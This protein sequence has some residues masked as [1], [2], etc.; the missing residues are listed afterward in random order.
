[1]PLEEH[2]TADLKNWVIHT[3]PAGQYATG[4]IYNDKRHRWRDGRPIRTSL[5]TEKGDDYIITLNSI[6]RL[7]A[8][9]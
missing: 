3:I 8:S 7:I 2:I 1:M 5:I 6:Y 4:N 9:D